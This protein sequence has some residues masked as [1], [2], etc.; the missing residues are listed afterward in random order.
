MVPLAS[1][2]KL[3]AVQGAIES[4]VS[5]SHLS[6]R[7]LPAAASEAKARLPSARVIIIIIVLVIKS[8][9]PSTYRS[10][11]GTLQNG[12]IFQYRLHNN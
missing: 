10:F 1:Q 6:A 4:C 9:P 12:R 2:P 3:L 5:T 11:N 7:K 8:D